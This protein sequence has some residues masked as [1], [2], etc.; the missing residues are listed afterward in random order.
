MTTSRPGQPGMR[1]PGA[2]ET[3]AAGASVP[4]IPQWFREWGCVPLGI[5]FLVLTALIADVGHAHG[6]GV[7]WFLFLLLL[8]GCAVT[9]CLAYRRRL[10]KARAAF[11]LGLLA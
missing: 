7:G 6:K 1:L 5:V 9:W 11:R 4:A 2:G 10:A 8:A 3:D